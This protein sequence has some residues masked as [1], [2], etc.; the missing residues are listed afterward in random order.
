MGTEIMKLETNKT[1]F[2]EPQ[3]SSLERMFR[4]VLM[5]KSSATWASPYYIFLFR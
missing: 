2:Q 4:R 3:Y 5:Y 1:Q